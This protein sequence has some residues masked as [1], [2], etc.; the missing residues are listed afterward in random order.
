VQR[1]LVFFESPLWFTSFGVHLC[2]IFFRYDKNAN[3]AIKGVVSA[4]RIL[5]DRYLLGSWCALTLLFNQKH[6]LKSS[7]PR[8]KCCNG[9]SSLFTKLCLLKMRS[10]SYYAFSSKYRAPRYN[11]CVAVSPCFRA[12]RNELTL[13]CSPLEGAS[14]PPHV[15]NARFLDGV[16][17]L[18]VASSTDYKVN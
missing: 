5:I 18:T 12:N 9:N 17:Q 14:E 6:L 2:N 11:L 7:A 1:I 13:M 10:H 16:Q 8:I 15:A 4:Q 3:V